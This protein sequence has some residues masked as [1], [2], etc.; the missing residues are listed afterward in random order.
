M[1]K[2]YLAAGALAGA[3]AVAL[4]AFGAHGLKKIVSPESVS[5]FQ[6]GV[7]YQM[8]HAFAL[9][10]VGILWERYPQKFIAWAGNCFISGIILFS[11][12]LY[13]LTFFIAAGKVGLEGIGIFTPIGGLFFIA[14]WLLLLLGIRKRD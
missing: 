13:L 3:L 9:L 4:G 5:V 2:K 14:G 1:H 7:Q 12:S 6:T 8:Y 11:G 10:I